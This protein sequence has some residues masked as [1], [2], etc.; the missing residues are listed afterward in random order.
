MGVTPAPPA[1]ALRQNEAIKVRRGFEHLTVRFAGWR[2]DSL[3][4]AFDIGDPLV[5]PIEEVSEIAAIRHS[6]DRAV[7]MGLLFGAITWVTIKATGVVAGGITQCRECARNSDIWMRTGRVVLVTTSLFLVA[8]Y[9]H[10]PY[11]VVYRRLAR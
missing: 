2:G 4:L 11:R 9:F 7:A 3:V 5:V 1:I 10:P 8:D 6:P